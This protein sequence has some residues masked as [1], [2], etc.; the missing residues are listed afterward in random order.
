MSA[1]AVWFCYSHGWICYYGDAEA[2]L[3]IARR[4]VDSQTPGYDQ[5]GTVWLPLPHLLMLPLVANDALWRNG[6]AGAIPSACCFLIAAC[7]L[8]AA[9]RRVFQSEAA[10]VAALGVFCLNPNLLYLQSTPMTEPVF[11]ACLM[12]LLYFTVRGWAAAAGIA[13]CAATLARYEGWFLIPFVAAYWLTFG[14]DRRKRLSHL[15]LFLAIASIGPLYWMFHNWYLTGDA[16]DFYRGP[17]SARAIQAGKN[18][19]GKDSWAASWLYFRT[20][21]ELCAGP[22]LPFLALAGIAAAIGKRVLWPLVLLALPV[23]FYIWSLHSSGTPI[24]VPPLWPH[25]YYNSRYGLAA[26]PLLAMAAAALVTVVPRRA[27]TIAAGVVIA[28]AVIPFAIHPRPVVWEES[29]VNSE[30]RRAWTNQT[31][32]YLAPRYTRGSDIFTSFGDMAGIY[33]ASGIPLRETF[34]GDNGLPWLAAVARPE[35]FVRQEWA[36][37]QAGDPVSRAIQRLPR[38]TLEKTITVKGAPAIEIY[39]RT[40]G[41]HGTS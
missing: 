26:L 38:Y 7:F 13:A 30:A 23:I 8:F 29:R 35:L 6:L 17:Y 15:V 5:I 28:A 3:N 10:A 9:A 20:A 34:T 16:L 31:A 2:H 4:I 1:G 37:A 24:F 32:E 18:Y 12:A 33:R 11:F 40:G 21:A 39:R 27:A 41:M 36:V 22:I 14:K 19:P 25:S